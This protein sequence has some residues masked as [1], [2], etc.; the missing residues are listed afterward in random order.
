MSDL[1]FDKAFLSG[2]WES[3]VRVRVDPA[4]FIGSVEADASPRGAERPAGVAVPGIP[5]LHSHAFQRAMAGLT[6][7]GSPSGDTFW[8]WRERMYGFL[9]SLSPDDVEAIAAQLYMDLLRHGFTAVAEFH[10]LR[11]DPHGHTY[12]DPVEMGRRIL[13]AAQRTGIGLT[14]L[15]VLYRA[16]DFGGVAPTEDQRRFTAS[17][18]DLVGDVV[19]LG[20]AAESPDQRVGLALHSLRAVPPADVAVAVEALRGIDADAPIHIHVAE[21]LREVEACLAWSGARPVQWLLDNAPVDDRWALIHATHVDDEEITRLATS[22]AT[23]GLCPTTEANLGD[24]V[25]PLKGYLGRKGSWGVGTDSH[26]GRSPV[27]ELRTLEYGQRLTLLGRNVAAGPHHRST[28]RVLLES[29]CDGGA[30]ACGRA[31]GRI[32]PGA[33]A[34]FVMLDPDHPALVG[35]AGDDLLD[36][37][38]FSCD[39]TPV[40]EVMVGGRWV[41]R[42]GRHVRQDEITARYAATVQQLAAETPQLT[43]AFEE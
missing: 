40:R 10:Y 7:R 4:G 6:E 38:I 24:G 19:V 26:V 35:R 2:S 17:V 3:H 34:D 21:Q 18:E 28:G 8:S 41:V 36:S 14:L 39:D 12:D 27:G 11:N 25:F 43:I 31:I 13:S 16:S 22:G 33:R 32:E 29:A 37:W 20:A 23:A 1:F 42:E 9:R 30:R 15:P 5:N